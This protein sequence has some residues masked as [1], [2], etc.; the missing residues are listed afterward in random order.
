MIYRENENP[1][2][3]WTPFEWRFGCLSCW[4]AKDIFESGR[5]LPVNGW[6]VSDSKIR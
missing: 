1:K 6:A 3:V 2:L 4:G 5:V